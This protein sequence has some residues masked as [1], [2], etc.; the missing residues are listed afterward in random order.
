ME[1]QFKK[2]DCSNMIRGSKIKI[3]NVHKGKI[4]KN[5]IIPFVYTVAYY[6]VNFSV[7]VAQCRNEP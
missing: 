5:V 2:I 7:C 6:I 4:V 3:K 1:V